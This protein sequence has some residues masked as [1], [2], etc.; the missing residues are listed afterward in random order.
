MRPR[1]WVCH[2]RP[3]TSGCGAFAMRAGGLVDR[4][5]P[6]G[7]V[8]TAQPRCSAHRGRPP[9]DTSRPSPAGLCPGRPRSTIYGVLRREGISRLS[10]IDRPTRTVVRYERERPGE[11]LHVDVKKLGRIRE[12]AAGR[13]TVGDRQPGAMTKPGRLRLPPC[14]RRRLQSGRLRPGAADEKG[15]PVPSSCATPRPIS[16]SRVTIERVM[17]DNALN[18]RTSK[19]FRR[20]STT[21]DHPQANQELPASDQ[22]QGRAVQP[23]SPRRVRL[24]DAL[25]HQRPSASPPSSPGSL[26]TIRIDLIRPSVG[27]PRCS[28]PSTTLTGITPRR[29]KQVS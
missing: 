23:D 21:R 8:R 29:S 6:P 15:R 24:Q 11:L 25:H 22:W 1:P 9:R 10:F 16:L 28:A 26:P 18:Y 12:A 5:R 14:G 2:A 3:P 17:T 19:N 27:S 20:R 4:R 13:I 7:A